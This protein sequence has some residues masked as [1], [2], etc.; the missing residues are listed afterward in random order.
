MACALSAR[1][2][3]AQIFVI[4]PLCKSSQKLNAPYRS[5]PSESWIKVIS[6]E[7]WAY[8]II[9]YMRHPQASDDRPWFW[10]ITAHEIPPSVY[11]R[12]YSATREQQ[13]R[14]LRRGGQP[15]HGYSRAL[16]WQEPWPLHTGQSCAVRIAG[17]AISM[18]VHIALNR[19]RSDRT[20]PSAYFGSD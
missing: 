11:N 9:Q 8:N 6:P 1:G 3:H 13:W 12:G 14:I 15:N 19:R 5:G 18:A 7:Y 4:H 2:R 17:T 16:L 10:T 20:F